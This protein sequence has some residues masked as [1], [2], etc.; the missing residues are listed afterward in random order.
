[1][2]SPFAFTAIW[3]GLLWCVEVPEG[4]LDERQQPR[5][6]RPSGADDGGEMSEEDCIRTPADSLA[7]LDALHLA[8]ATSFS[9]A[10]WVGQASVGCAIAFS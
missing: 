3:I 4:R 2:A 5:H 6:L 8:R 1:M 10:R 7:Q 9:I